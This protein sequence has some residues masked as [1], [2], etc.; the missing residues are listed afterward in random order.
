MFFSLDSWLRCA[1]GKAFENEL[2]V[3]D[4]KI[5]VVQ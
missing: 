2:D 4:E 1:R 3:L 5:R